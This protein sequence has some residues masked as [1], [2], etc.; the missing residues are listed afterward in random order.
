MSKSALAILEAWARGDND[1]R[2]KKP[3][4]N[5]YNKQKDRVKYKAYQNGYKA[6]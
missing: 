3:Y 6:R 2:L 4:K 1:A 5:P